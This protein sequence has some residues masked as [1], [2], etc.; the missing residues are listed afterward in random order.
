MRSY[1]CGEEHSSLEDSAS[2]VAETEFASFRSNVATDKSTRGSRPEEDTASVRSSEATVNQP[3]PSYDDRKGKENSTYKLF[4]PEDAAFIIQS[5]FRNFMVNII[6]FVFIAYT[7]ALS[8]IYIY[9]D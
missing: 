7:Y 4:Q 2:T 5:A 8:S 9:I 6:T 1:L 3:A